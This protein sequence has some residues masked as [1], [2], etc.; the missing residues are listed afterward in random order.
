MCVIYSHSF[1]E[2]IKLTILKDPLHS[3]KLDNQLMKHFTRFNVHFERSHDYG[4]SR[5]H[6]IVKHEQ[7]GTG[8][9]T[10]IYF[11]NWP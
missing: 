7:P 10:I 3:S 9:W 4:G 1:K 11:T 2:K 8:L 6:K 5:C